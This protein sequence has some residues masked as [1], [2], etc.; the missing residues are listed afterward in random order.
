MDNLILII[1]PIIAVFIAIYNAFIAPNI[2]KEK[3]NKANENSITNG[4]LN[5]LMS[6]S[7]ED[8]IAK[9]FTSKLTDLL[10]PD[11]KNMN[12]TKEEEKD[13]IHNIPK[14]LFEGSILVLFLAYE[15]INKT[16]NSSITIK[17]MA[18]FAISSTLSA[19]KYMAFGFSDKFTDSMYKAVFRTRFFLYSQKSVTQIKNI[20]CN[21]TFEDIKTNRCCI[22]T[23]IS[24]NVI[25]GNPMMLE[26]I[27]KI[28]LDK[29]LFI[30]SELVA[31]Y[32]FKNIVEV[33]SQDENHNKDELSFERYA[34]STSAKVA[35][36]F[37]KF[38]L[39]DLSEDEKIYYLFVYSTE[40]LLEIYSTIIINKNTSINENGIFPSLICY[41]ERITP[42]NHKGLI[43]WS[44]VIF[45][46]C[47][48][49][50]QMQNIDSDL[51]SSN[52]AKICQ[53]ELDNQT[54][55]TYETLDNVPSIIYDDKLNSFYLEV[56]KTGIKEELSQKIIKYL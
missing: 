9:F 26:H 27:N 14:Y 25:C 16:K 3:L 1:L 51:Y 29:K 5:Q 44:N 34:I 24:D 48:M 33:E 36:V 11:I 19:F 45:S 54:I 38:N 23:K 43:D 41:L 17:Q 50:R 12:L 49:Y 52:F 37:S 47:K 28:F 13:F 20:F 2:E 31:D 46:R 40:F 42:P 10:C 39:K 32:I 55:Y 53:H 35:Q 30:F 21:L 4:K 56:L 18:N 15:S 8:F 22:S 6:L 7:S